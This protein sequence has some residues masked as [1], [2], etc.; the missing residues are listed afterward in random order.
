VIL[1]SDAF[2]SDAALAF[3]E[4][5]VHLFRWWLRSTEGR[6]ELNEIA[7]GN[8]FDNFSWKN[9]R[10]PFGDPT[11]P[12][13]NITGGSLIMVVAAFEFGTIVQRAMESRGPRVD[14]VLLLLCAGLFFLGIKTFR[15]GLTY[16]PQ[17]PSD[18]G[19]DRRVQRTTVEW[20]GLLLF[21]IVLIGAPVAII[22]VFARR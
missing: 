2:I 7:G 8:V 4:V 10:H 1:S 16:V 18:Q 6:D 13:R 9:A 11:F 17:D 19:T 20:I 21:W 12:K 5:R 15:N 22:Q 3:A 14:Y